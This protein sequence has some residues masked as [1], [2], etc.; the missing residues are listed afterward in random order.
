MKH[1]KLEDFHKDN[2]HLYVEKPDPK[3][4]PERNY[5]VISDTI[6]EYEKARYGIDPKVQAAAADRADILTSYGIYRFN[7]GT[8]KIEE[9]LGREMM[10]QIYGEKLMQRI[11]ALETIKRLNIKNGNTKFSDYYLT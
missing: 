1:A 5:K 8:K 7:R 4:S 10:A 3:F 6:V 2:Y 9:Y 11:K